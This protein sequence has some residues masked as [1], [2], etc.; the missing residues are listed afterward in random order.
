MQL[1]KAGEEPDRD[2]IGEMRQAQEAL[3]LEMAVSQWVIASQPEEVNLELMRKQDWS[4]WPKKCNQ[5][6]KLA[7]VTLLKEFLHVFAWT[8]EDMRIWTHNYINTRFI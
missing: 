1:E 5:K 2:A 3:E 7:M 4:M 6:Q 8:Y